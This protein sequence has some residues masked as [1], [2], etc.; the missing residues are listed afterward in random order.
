MSK[1]IVDLQ[2]TSSSRGWTRTGPSLML[3]FVFVLALVATL[4]LPGIQSQPG[5]TMPIIA[6]AL[7]LGICLGALWLRQR[8]QGGELRVDVVIAKAHYV[9]TGVQIAVYAY[10]GWYWRP[11]YD[12]LPLILAQLLLVYAVDMLLSLTRRRRF[13]L[14]FGPFP[15]V[16]ST[17]LF[18][19]F[20][21][22]WFFLQFAMIVLGVLGKEFIRWKRNGRT[23]H[24]FNPSAFALF[25]FSVGLLVTGTT[26]ITWGQEIATTLNRPPHIYLQIFLLG[27]I[28][29]ALFSVTLITLWSV[30]AL[31][32]LNLIYTAAT[33]VYFFV[34]SNIPIAVFLG[35]H[36]LVTDPATSPRTSF[37]KVLFGVGYGIAVFALFGILETMGMPKFY[38]K[39][40]CVPILNLLVPVFDRV[41]RV[42]VGKL[43]WPDWLPYWLPKGNRAHMTL[44]IIVFVAMFSTGFVGKSHPGTEVAYWQSACNEGKRHACRNL[45]DLHTDNCAIGSPLACRE[46]AELHNR[47]APFAV[48]PL[49]EGTLLARACDLGDEA[50][51][52]HLAVFI[53]DGGE[54][55]LQRDC[56]ARGGQSCYI[57]GTLAMYGLGLDRDSGA[58][59]VMWQKACDTGV[60]RAC[61]DLGETWLFGRGVEAAPV[62]AAQVFR[63]ACDAGHL[64]GCANLGLMYLGGSGIP[65]DEVRGRRLLQ[66]ACTKGL[67]AACKLVDLRE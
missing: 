51:C 56:E 61:I 16:L 41:G 28:V 42:S 37:G 8:R 52:D 22:E 33:G 21:A 12:H 5:V 64:P 18:L 66:Q 35:L 44:W 38:D 4:V 6:A 50:S 39:L 14:G 30:I 29:Q 46:A 59:I 67:D 27:L 48:N 55:V 24:I 54:L 23:T 49:R 20:K 47:G 58:A 45:L 13:A 26:D 9:Q 7:G 11:V 2:D 60:G 10:W 17:N 32:C 1:L 3:A 19:M 31:V 43:A 57:L 65:E 15:I 53:K 25:V 62:R 63:T 34:D 40:L 36:L